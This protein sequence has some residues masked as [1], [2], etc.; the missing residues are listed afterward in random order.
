MADQV[1]THEGRD[2][3]LHPGAG[4]ED[5]EQPRAV[6]ED[7]ESE[8]NEAHYSVCLLGY[9]LGDDDEEHVVAVDANQAHGNCCKVV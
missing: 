9:K 7:K 3:G 6:K 2:T 4:Q 5:E 1:Y 8:A